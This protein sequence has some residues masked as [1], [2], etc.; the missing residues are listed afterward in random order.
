[1]ET[2]PKKLLDQVRDALR[3]KNYAYSTEKT[4]VDSGASGRERYIR[5]HKLP[6]PLGCRPKRSALNAKS[7]PQRLALSLS[8]CSAY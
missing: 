6:H 4:Y 8:Q 1:M 5:F 3:L 7:G 2:E